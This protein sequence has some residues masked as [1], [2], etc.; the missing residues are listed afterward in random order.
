MAILTITR[1]GNM[2]GYTLAFNDFLKGDS[3]DAVKEAV[4]EANN[5]N[6]SNIE[7]IMERIKQ[8]KIRN[9]IIAKNKKQRA[10]VLSNN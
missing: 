2:F 1:H 6:Q 8:I 4:R 9:A 5:I 10:E 7:I 3:L